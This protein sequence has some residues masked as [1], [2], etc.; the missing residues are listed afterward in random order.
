[1]DAIKKEVRFEPYE[2]DS[3]VLLRQDKSPTYNFACAC[4]DLL[5]EI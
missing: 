2:L 3:F 1:N 4:D 5:Y